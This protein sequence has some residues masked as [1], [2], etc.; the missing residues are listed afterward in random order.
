MQC[1]ENNTISSTSE[2][3]S[4]KLKMDAKDS[5]FP[6]KSIVLNLDITTGEKRKESF[7]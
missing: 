1:V 7:F 4:L 5:L 3:I 2:T 6:M